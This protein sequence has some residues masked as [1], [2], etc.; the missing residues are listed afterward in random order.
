MKA[1]DSHWFS[2]S[3]G[4]VGVVKAE[5]ENTG[6]V[7]YRLAP[8]DGFNR[9]VDINCVLAWGVEFPEVAGAALFAGVLNHG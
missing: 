3:R 4:I 5:D 9:Q 8:V 6:R 1:L 7:A 2:G